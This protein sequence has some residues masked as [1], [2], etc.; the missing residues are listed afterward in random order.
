MLNT[1]QTILASRPAALIL[2]LTLVA[3]LAAPFVMLPRAQAVTSP[4][5]CA[6]ANH[7][8]CTELSATPPEDMVTVPPNLVLMLDDSGSMDSD[9][10][11]DWNSLKDSSNTGVRDT[12]INGVYYDPTVLYSPP[13]QADGT[14][15]PDS[16]GSTDAYGLTDAYKD[17]FLDTSTTNILNYTSPDGGFP[18]YTTLPIPGIDKGAAVINCPSGYS[19]DPSNP[20]QCIRPP[21]NPVSPRTSYTCSGNDRLRGSTCYPRNPE[22]PPYPATAHYGC[23]SGSTYDSSDGMCHYPLDYYP[24][25]TPTWTCPNG[26]SPTRQ[27]NGT[28]ECIQ[29][30]SV[31]VFVYVTGNPYGT[32][33]SPYVTH[34][35]AAG[36]DCDQVTNATQKANCVNEGDTSGVAAPNKD[37][38]GNTLKDQ[39]GNDLTAGQN[40]ANWF[41]YY[42][43]RM[44]MAKSSLMKAFTKVGPNY[45][46]GFASINA[47]GV[48][49]IPS[50]PAPYGFDDSTYGG[51]SSSNKLAVVQPFGDGSPGTQKAKF[52]NW[53]INESAAGNT[54]LRKALQGVG[55]YYKTS[56]PWTAMSSDPG[57]SSNPHAQFSCRASYA[58]LTTDGFWNGATPSVGNADNTSSGPYTVP[59]GAL[60]G[61]TPKDPFKD[62]QSNTLADVAMYYWQTDLSSMPNEVGTTTADP[63]SWQH[64]TTFTVG[65]GFDP[66]YADQ[67]TTIPMDQV[68]AWAQGGPAIS[69]FQWPTPSSNSINN[70]ADLAHAAVNGHGDFFSAK[71]PDD[72][73]NAFGAITNDI[74]G[75]QSTTPAASVS[76]SV[77]SL[78]A[79]SFSTGYSTKDWSGQLEGVALQA[80][81]TV[82]PCS[83]L[84]NAASGICPTGAALPQ[85]TLDSDFHTTTG[86]TNRKVYTNAYDPT[87]P[88][89]FSTFQFTTANAASLDSTE[90]AGLGGNTDCT[91]SGDTLCNRV[92]YLL[93]S[94]EYEGA[95]GGY[96]ARSTI[97][98]AIIRSEP[99]YVAAPTGNYYDT[100]PTSI[101][102]VPVSAPEDA[103]DA[104]AYSAFV[105]QETQ[106]ATAR[107]GMVYVGANDGM[108]HAFNAPTPICSGGMDSAT[109]NCSGGYTF[110]SG[111]NAGHEA[112]AFV[113]R[114]V[115]A[116]LGNLVNASNFIFLPTVDATPMARDVFFSDKNWHTILA[117]GVG[118]GGRGVYALDI[119]DP[120]SFSASNVLWEFDADMADLATGCVSIVGGGQSGSCKSS[121]LGYT[122]SGPNIGRLSNG[123]WVVLVSNGYFPDCNT[124]D[125]PTATQA[126]CQAIAAQAPR[127]TSGN[128]YSALFVMDAQTGKMLAEL[129][130]PTTIAGVT[131]FGLSTPVMGDYDNNQVDDVAFAGDVQGNLWRFDLS[132]TSASDWKVTLVYKGLADASGNQGLQPITTMPRLFPDPVTNRLMVVFGTGKLL[133][134]GDNGN[135]TVQAIYAVRD[136]GNTYSQGNLTP[137][138]LH[139]TMISA[140]A[141]LPDGSP[142]PNAGATLRC[143]TGSANDT[144]CTSTT[145]SA[146]TPVGA[147]PSGSG[148][149]YLNLCTV[150]SG[151]SPCGTSGAVQ[152][153]AGERV[154]VTPGSIFATNEVVFETLITGSQ[155]SD[156]C[157]PATQGSILVL[158][159][160]SG[161]AAG[162]SSLG[163][164]FIAGARINNAR[165]RG[166]LPIVMAQSGGIAYAAGTEL[167]PNGKTPFS[168]DA[169][170]L[171]RRAW[172]EINQNQ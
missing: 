166:S 48:S 77:L 118:L 39:A 59:S 36:T 82:D 24:P 102:G 55:D 125:I 116:N 86:Y 32:P 105:T 110:P 75:R 40:V 133:G 171:R 103:T 26:G 172:S 88:T 145:T 146:P 144:S 67:T 13:P 17:G 76:A 28:Y 151:S 65:L 117:G 52:W 122:V 63:A 80:D 54:P 83:P 152:N 95:A 34:Y 85:G 106:G 50:T 109:G 3:G 41:S 38:D 123:K 72:L 33:S 140:G 101:G 46:F 93:G 104:Q 163:G 69:G 7:N 60:S 119:T 49:N 111:S 89:P 135:S 159:A 136:D 134:V 121:D 25:K 9:F 148:G 30:Q 2:A 164:G 29:A 155:S 90:T 124:P 162:V 170:I 97:L 23:P 128:P 141:T 68:F 16:H 169:P 161:V 42:R 10:M 138:Y 79:V 92:A 127:D 15:F 47:N 14:L 94:P 31:R 150:V 70:I 18:Y 62:D 91:A 165:T 147:V 6:E 132:S 142:D 56:Q 74:N 114:A 8:G 66:K 129:K 131:S 160:D 130:T 11:P 143:V 4:L 64:M 139:E 108:L 158:D 154:V 35:V 112:W 43:T 100:W 57:Y 81:G 45:R 53:I 84:W 120:T 107:S 149:W 21:P 167:A 153:D 44:L 115:Y 98:G 137:R 78:G 12:A 87:K 58:I 27:S 126:Q 73:A 22:N 1:R 99:V 20:G 61:Y 19:P 157:N 5:P 113:P 156:P 37:A 168:F 96:R 71:T 51:G